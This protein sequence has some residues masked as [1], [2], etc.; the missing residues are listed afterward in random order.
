MGGVGGEEAKGDYV[1]TLARIHNINSRCAWL[2]CAQGA[3]HACM[4]LAVHGWMGMQ[5]HICC[6][7]RIRLHT[8]PPPRIES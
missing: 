1:D 2:V 5:W 8:L 3:G 7:I 4:V 6:P